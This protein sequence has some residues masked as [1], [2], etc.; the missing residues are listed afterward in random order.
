MERDSDSFSITTSAS[1]NSDARDAFH[2]RRSTEIVDQ[3]I[4]RLS[5]S[6]WWMMKLRFATAI[7][8]S[9]PSGASTPA[10]RVCWLPRRASSLTSRQLPG[11]GRRRDRCPYRG[12]RSPQCARA[13]PECGAAPWLPSGPSQQHRFAANIVI[14]PGLEPAV[15][16]EVDLAAEDLFEE[17]LEADEP[18]H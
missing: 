1:W 14:E 15:V 8:H 5:S 10:W 17:L 4:T 3:V 16:D 11:V 9:T 7:A 13:N 2:S 6:Y 18:E 12:R